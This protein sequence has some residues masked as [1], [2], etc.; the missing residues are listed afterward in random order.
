MIRYTIK[1]KC[2]TKLEGQFP[3]KESFK[4][5]KRQ[6][7]IQCPMCDSLD[8]SYS[9]PKTKENTKTVDQRLT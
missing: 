7:M 6:G 4:K 3:D 2:T 1:C 5:Q 9:K 8:L